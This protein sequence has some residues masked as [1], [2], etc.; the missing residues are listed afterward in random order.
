MIGFILLTIML[1]GGFIFLI[2]PLY[3]S[4]KQEVS[5]KITKFSTKDIKAILIFVSTLRTGEP[6][7]SLLAHQVLSQMTSNN[8]GTKFAWLIHGDISN[9]EGSSYYNTYQL[10]KKFRSDTF[11]I[12]TYGVDNAFETKEIFILANKI[13]TQENFG[14]RPKDIVCDCTSGTKLVTLGI[15][16]AAVRN[17]RLVYFLKGDTGEATEYIEID[18][19]IFADTIKAVE[20]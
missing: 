14:I 9:E 12:Q 1:I 18:T 20:E 13:L 19:E 10:T 5:L 3:R 4:P 15:T 2:V 8:N 16:L 6:L 17:G 11:K 7:E